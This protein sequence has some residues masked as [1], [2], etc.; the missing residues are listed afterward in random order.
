MLAARDAALEGT[1][2]I[3]AAGARYSLGGAGD[4]GGATVSGAGWALDVPATSPIA[5]RFLELSS[6]EFRRSKIV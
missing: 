1:A 5:L 4:G 6:N 3:N 2:A